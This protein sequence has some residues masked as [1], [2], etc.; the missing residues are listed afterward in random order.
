ML[1]DRQCRLVWIDR[2][3]IGQLDYLADAVEEQ[4]LAAVIRPLSQVTGVYVKD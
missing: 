1:P 2:H 3:V 4:S